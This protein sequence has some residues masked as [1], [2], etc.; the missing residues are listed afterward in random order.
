[1]LLES[2]KNIQQQ[3]EYDCLVCCCQQILGNL[4][5]DQ[6]EKWLWRQLQASTGEVTSFTN[7]K[8]LEASLGLVIE[9]H[10]GN[11]NI[12]QFA[13]Y[14]E[15]GLPIV[16]AVDADIPSSWPFCQ[17][18]AVVVIGFDSE[19]VYVNDPAQDETGL[20]VGIDT[21]LL[22]WSRRSYTFAVIRLT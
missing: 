8:K 19:H 18:H 22:A 1:M 15:S 21:F 11:D 12:E 2:I 17:Q 10:H 4:G 13:P 7:L 16:I 6:S 14:I 5:I 20:A 9:M 3:Y